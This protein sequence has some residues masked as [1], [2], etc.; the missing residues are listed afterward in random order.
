MRRRKV[1]KN[2][3]DRA[4][5]TAFFCDIIEPGEPVIRLVQEK[6]PHGAFLVQIDKTAPA[7]LQ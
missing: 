4:A 2:K 6:A 5:K 1:A 7:M 3:K